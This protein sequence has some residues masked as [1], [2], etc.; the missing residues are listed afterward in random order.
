M[1]INTLLFFYIFTFIQ[2]IF[3]SFYSLL[4]MAPK[5]PPHVASSSEDPSSKKSKPKLFHFSTSYS[6]QEIMKRASQF[7]KRSFVASWF[8]HETTLQNL[9]CYDEIKELHLRGGL[10]Q[11]AFNAL[12]SYPS[13]IIKFLSS[14]TLCSINYDNKNPYFSMRFKL[15]GKDHFMTH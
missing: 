12:P 5:K 10:F 14:F 3:F 8:M 11:F 1:P 9:G 6:S 15:E 4:S 7:S 13:L 2:T